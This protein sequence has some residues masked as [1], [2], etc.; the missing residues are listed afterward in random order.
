MSISDKLNKNA[1]FQLHI[2]IYSSTMRIPRTKVGLMVIGVLGLLTVPQIAGGEEN[3]PAT[4]EGKQLQDEE[5][6]YDFQISF[7]VDSGEATNVNDGRKASIEN[8]LQSILLE[9][10]ALVSC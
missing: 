10:E 1:Y 9:N 3:A 5:Q 6:K 7:P 4:R 8:L 2:Y